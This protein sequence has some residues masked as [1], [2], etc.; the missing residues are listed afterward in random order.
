MLGCDEI[1]LV[2]E[3]AKLL[4]LAGDEALIFKEV[5]IA[6]C[7]LRSWV[8]DG[9]AVRLKVVASWISA[10][11]HELSLV[12]ERI[13]HLVPAMAGRSFVLSLKLEILRA[14]VFGMLACERAFV[15]VLCPARLDVSGLNLMLRLR[16]LGTHALTEGQG[17]E[18]EKVGANHGVFLI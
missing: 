8:D 5:A 6:S 18:S 10:L 1:L 14:D 17:E 4:R 2:E 3:V 11:V 7:C 9:G 13:R 16:L 15:V 12:V